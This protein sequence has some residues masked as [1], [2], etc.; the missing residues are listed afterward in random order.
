MPATS[1]VGTAWERAP[2]KRSSRI[3]AGPTRP[4]RPRASA[5]TPLPKDQGQRL[6]P[7]PQT[8]P[9]D[10]TPP[11]RP[12]YRSCHAPPSRGTR[13]KFPEACT[14]AHRAEA[15]AALGRQ[16][17][18]RMK[19]SR[20]SFRSPCPVR[21]LGPG[22]GPHPIWDVGAAQGNTEVCEIRL[23][24]KAEFST[25]SC[26]AVLP[27]GQRKIS[28]WN[29]GPDGSLSGRPT[30]GRK[31]LAIG[32]SILPFQLA[33]LGAGGDGTGSRAAPIHPFLVE[34]SS[35]SFTAGPALR[36]LQEICGLLRPQRLRGSPRRSAGPEEDQACLRAPRSGLARDNVTH[37]PHER[38]PPASL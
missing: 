19:E 35:R 23:S 4:Q 32:R 33:A 30:D 38:P 12:N 6:R 3:P 2:L 17:A 10:G 36:P 14:S 27:S 15:S 25:E 7:S 8:M 1:P 18:C 21:P 13:L 26:C 11:E 9:L 31:F 28:A 34:G 22:R 29:R 5:G 24:R 20:L 16:P 37:L